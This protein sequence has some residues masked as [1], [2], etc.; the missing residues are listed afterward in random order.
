MFT[1][2]FQSKHE[3]IAEAEMLL[4]LNVQCKLQIRPFFLKFGNAKNHT[5]ISDAISDGDFNRIL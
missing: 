5:V 1:M 3:S 2:F 4:L